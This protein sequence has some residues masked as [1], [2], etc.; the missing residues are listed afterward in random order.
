[1]LEMAFANDA[2]A[3]AALTAAGV[4]HPLAVALIAHWRAEKEAKQVHVFGVVTS[5]DKAQLLREKVT[6]TREQYVKKLMP[7]AAARL[8]LKSYG[9]PDPVA[10]ALLALWAA[11]S[12]KEVLPP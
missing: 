9:I 7:E 4:P 2:L 8:A 6:A 3:I 11:Q 5:H 10:H 1:L 12:H